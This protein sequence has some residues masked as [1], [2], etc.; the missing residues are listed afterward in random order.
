MA[1]MA[2]DGGAGGNPAAA[3]RAAFRRGVRA[4]APFLLVVAPFGMVFGVIGIEAGLG[5]AEVMGF[6]IFVIAGASQLAAVQLMAEGAPLAVVLATALAINLRMAMYSAALAPHLGALPMGRRGVMAYFLVDQS[7]A[8]S[9]LEFESRP[10]MTVEEKAAYFFGVIAPVCLPWYAATLAGALLGTGLP[11]GWGLD[12]AVPIT[13]LAVVA[14]MLRTPAHVAAAGVSVAGALT[15]AVLPWNL[16]LL[17]AA[18]GA[19]AAG[20]AVE[21]ASERRAAR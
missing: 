3:R 17:L 10:D 2:E 12:F 19:M 20:A 6:S 14:P 13:F 21:I 11:P 4:G 15:L 18:L 9:A 16:G 1:G 8:A 5:L 7:F